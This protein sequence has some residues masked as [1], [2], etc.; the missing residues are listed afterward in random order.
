MGLLYLNG[1]DG[2]EI[3]AE[4]AAYW[5][6]LAAEKGNMAAK[7]QLGLLYLNGE[8]VEEDLQKGKLLLEQAAEN[9]NVEAQYNLA[10]MY[11]DGHGVEQNNEYAIF[12][13]QKAASQGSEIAIKALN[14][15]IKKQA[16][17]T[18]NY[19]SQNAAELYQLITAEQQRRESTNNINSNNQL[20][21]QLIV[22]E[23]Q[24]RRNPNQG[25]RT[26]N[27]DQPLSRW[28]TA[29]P[30]PGENANQGIRKYSNEISENAP[31]ENHAT[32]VM[33]PVVDR[34]KK[35]INDQVARIQR[36]IERLNERIEDGESDRTYE[37]Y[38]QLKSPVFVIHDRERLKA[39]QTELDKLLLER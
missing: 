9:G 18:V 20:L 38:K 23:R 36:E 6:S 34:N 22:A 10:V 32:T 19:N 27:N 8:G 11:L 31:K 37:R 7:Y 28:I 4:T 26:N 25:S 30:Q 29:E 14:S 24:R 2:F 21:H 3:D 12:W 1:N 35:Y 33:K 17:N 15:I 5:F 13:L 39:Y 16:E